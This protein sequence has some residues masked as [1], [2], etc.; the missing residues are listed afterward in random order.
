MKRLDD[1][2]AADLTALT[3]LAGL[4]AKA[5][6][7]SPAAPAPPSPPKAKAPDRYDSAP[8]SPPRTDG[9]LL[10]ALDVGKYLTHY[11]VT[12]EIKERLGSSGR[13]VYALAH[14]LFDMNHGKGEAAIIQDGTGRITYHC[15]HQSCNH[16]WAEARRVI[17]GEDKIVQFCAGYDPSMGRGRGPKPETKP[18]TKPEERSPFDDIQEGDGGGSDPGCV[19]PEVADD[20]GSVPEPGDVVPGWFFENKRFMP[21]F[22]AVYL[23]RYLSPIKYDGSSFYKYTDVGMWKK[24]PDDSV[25]QISDKAMGK[26]AASAKIK[27]AVTLLKHR[28]FIPPEDFQHDPGF[29]NLRS[30]MLDLESLLMVP[31]DQKYNS[32]FQLPVNYNMESRAERWEKFLEE[33]FPGED[34]RQKALCLQSFFGYCLLPDCRFQRC[35]FLIGNGSNGKS[36]IIDILVDLLGQEN[37]SSLPMQ[38]FSQRFLIGQLKDKLINVAG[39]I[40]TQGII[41]TDVFKNA[42]SGGLLMADEKHGKPYGFYP[43]AKHIFA[44]NEVPK[45]TDK[46]YGFARRPIVLKF[47][48]QFDGDKKDPNLTNMLRSELDGIFLWMLDGLN[49]ILANKDLYIPKVV[50]ADGQEFLATANPVLLFFDEC[51]VVGDDRFVAPQKLYD[52]YLDWCNS[53]KQRPMSRNRFY[54]QL[55]LHFKAVRRSQ[56]G[57]NRMRVFTGIGLQGV[58]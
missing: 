39:E 29:L 38:L 45:I 7:A 57:P 40:S 56:I 42:V 53:G 20:G 24:Y 50:D 15:Y 8:A 54:S 25:C 21:A 6:P 32:R 43:H 1:I 27:D 16:H 12:F 47:T 4:V 11:G 36:V 51:C 46:S 5:E 33:V 13:T 19:D 35:L 2:L 14:C 22:L 18:E 26:Q 9:N 28:V 34:G 10:G 55:L 31:H 48:E 49:M 52:T 41:D 58:L 3:T 37:V 23:D 30:G 44:M 17:S